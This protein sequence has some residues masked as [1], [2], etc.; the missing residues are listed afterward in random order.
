MKYGQGNKFPDWDT[1]Y[2][3]P[4]KKLMD[5]KLGVTKVDAKGVETVVTPAVELTVDELSTVAYLQN[6]KLQRT[7]ILNEFN[8]AHTLEEV[9]KVIQ[10]Y[11]EKEL[12]KDAHLYGNLGDSTKVIADP[13]YNTRAEKLRGRMIA[14]ESSIKEHNMKLEHQN[15]KE[16]ERLKKTIAPSLADQKKLNADI[17]KYK[18]QLEKAQAE[19]PKVWNKGDKF[20]SV[21]AKIVEL[22]KKI[23]ELQKA[24]IPSTPEEIA[25][26]R[27]KIS[28][29]N[30]ERWGA[31]PGIS[32]DMTENLK[33]NRKEPAIL[34]H[35]EKDDIRKRIMD[36]RMAMDEANGVKVNFKSA[37]ENAT[38][39]ELI[40]DQVE[41]LLQ[42]KYPKGLNDFNS[43]Q[44][45]EINAVLELNYV[46]GL[47]E[48]NAFQIRQ[49]ESVTGIPF[50]KGF[51]DLSSFQ[52]NSLIRWATDNAESLEKGERL[53]GGYTA[54]QNA[55]FAK[56]IKQRA[57]MDKMNTI[58]SQIENGS[59]VLLPIGVGKIQEI[60][61]GNVGQHSYTV[62]MRDGRTVTA[63]PGD[64]ARV[65]KKESTIEEKVAEVQIEKAIETSRITGE[66][67][68]GI[69]S[70]QKIIEDSIEKLKVTNHETRQ[71]KMK[72][73]DDY[74]TQTHNV[75]AN[76]EELEI[77]KRNLEEAYKQGKFDPVEDVLKNLHK[78]NIAKSATRLDDIEKQ[79]K[80]FN[81]DTPPKQYPDID[82]SKLSREED[83]L[84]RIRQAR[85]KVSLETFNKEVANYKKLTDEKKLLE[86]KSTESMDKLTE[87][88]KKAIPQADSD[89]IEKL[90]AKLKETED[91]LLNDDAL[92]TFMKTSIGE[93]AY[94][95]IARANDAKMG[96]LF[97]DTMTD[98]PE[99]VIRA[100][101]LLHD[102]FARI[103][104]EEVKAG[105]LTQGQFDA[106]TNEY[107]FHLL[108]P[109]GEKHFAKV[110][111]KG[112]GTFGDVYG[113]GRKSFNGSG[114]SRTAINLPDGL[115]GVIHHPTIEQI[116]AHFAE[117]LKGKNLFSE[118]VFEIYQARAS[119]SVEMLYDTKY[120]D[121]MLSVFGKD[122]VG[123]EKGFNTVM[124]Y[125]KLKSASQDVS[126]LGVDMQISRATTD[127]VKSQ[128]IP[129]LAS[130]TVVNR[131]GLQ[132]NGR[133]PMFDTPMQ[134][135]EY[136]KAV[137]AEIGRHAEMFVKENF[138]NATRKQ[139]FADGVDGFAG[140]KLG[141]LATPM[142]EFD[143]VG[144]T[145]VKGAF[146]GVLGEYTSH[147]KEKL[148]NTMVGF[149]YN[150]VG[151]VMDKADKKKLMEE[152][153]TL[154]LVDMRSKVDLLKEGRDVVDVARV[155]R[156]IGNLDKLEKVKPL[157][158]K[159]VNDVIV[160]KANQMRK[161]Q[162]YKDQRR[163]LQIY[164]K[165]THIIK[166]NQTTILPQFHARNK[167]SN[168]FL[169]WLGVGSDAVNKEFQIQAY[170]AVH[171]KGEVEGMLK[172]KDAHGVESEIP[173]SEVYAEARRND[174]IGK[175]FFKQDEVLDVGG[176]ETVKGNWKPW[177]T[178][179]FIPY[180][181][182]S[183]FGSL[184]EDQDRLI[185]F[186][187]QVS[188]GMGFEEAGISANKYLF[189]YGDLT[190]F[191]QSVM[192]R[193]MPYYT[194]LRKNSVLQVDQMIQHPEKYQYVA[195]VMGGI[196]GMVD[197]EDRIN[198]FF[199]NDFALDWIQT[200]FEVTNPDGVKEPVL[201]NPNLPFMDLSRIPDIT[202]P[203]D[204]LKGLFSQSNPIFKTP[205]E[206]IANKNVF[207]DSPIT[208]T[209]KWKM[210]NP[211]LGRVTGETK[212]NQVTDRLDHVAGQNGAF[213]VLKGF[214]TK[215][216]VDLGLHALNSGLGVKALSYNY[217]G[218]KG[219][220]L[221]QMIESG[222]WG[223]EPLNIHDIRKKFHDIKRYLDG[224]SYEGD[225]AETLPDS[226]FDADT[227]TDEKA[228]TIKHNL[229]V[230]M[231]MEAMARML[232]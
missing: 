230:K 199:V 113:Y 191:E 46:E 67:E 72:L 203:V 6:L 73:R 49:V 217:E 145:E 100:T 223:E 59:D 134:A 146:D 19:L 158:I 89:T 35:S 119:R 25:S 124:N 186:A 99:K 104:M 87:L 22:K 215:S 17:G 31:T 78:H 132:M 58:K 143:H 69:A 183:A 106:L 175:G 64:V 131:M 130:R 95:K 56:D 212:G 36:S 37:K 79:L 42:K 231:R 118:N 84:Y 220:K 1:L 225:P 164:D 129:A 23:P 39:M 229:N 140:K 41:P 157:E 109:A 154:S 184:I 120:T 83:T 85:G 128:G 121:E 60:K 54:E 202:H 98:V 26:V 62:L 74:V 48:L 127:Y 111:A 163:W 126:R 148:F 9:Q 161:L 2:E 214:A 213:S 80:N 153:E 93:N 53:I 88:N 232:K 180:K 168:T 147:I 208:D 151:K 192:K 173:W 176:R 33:V 28:D 201:L 162:I 136:K 197:E 200:P 27:M 7:L 82:M 187:S 144:V 18:K 16:I 174:A 182:G 97:L 81:L 11:K 228:E 40:L 198:P 44:V 123:V 34:L 68:D 12:L 43:R 107:L 108:T 135:L 14:N 15:G 103:G 150:D 125:G 210:D 139:M 8:G 224:D 190:S 216:G 155:D 204:S 219:V 102:E 169:N 133:F 141:D 137:S 218:Y 94:D 52:Q 86:F 156:L 75:R 179:N 122:Y 76:L 211:K 91:M 3:A 160:Q 92:D 71:A 189:D 206:Q 32:K 77:N 181:K 30:N 24:R 172:I 205:I 110:D 55:K 196:K 209:S 195:K 221:A 152:L 66:F 188:R 90:T 116:N 65:F 165:F 38:K 13:I 167:I 222:D 171:N 5:K 21:Y 10:K 70:H 112:V 177:D 159:S 114:I 194:W 185:H 29:L 57:D 96:M 105:K 226:F 50:K 115:G 63:V 117:E 193:I 142:I 4:I 61:V 51:A 47:T 207:F 20:D 227:T 166:L 170:R 178:K 45:R 149:H 138:D 101:H